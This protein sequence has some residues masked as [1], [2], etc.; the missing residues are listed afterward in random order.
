MQASKR[1]ASGLPGA[2][3]SRPAIDGARVGVVSN[4]DGSYELKLRIPI[5]IGSPRGCPPSS[6]GA[7]RRFLLA[8]RFLRDWAEALNRQVPRLIDVLRYASAINFPWFLNAIRECH[9]GRRIPELTSRDWLEL[10]D[11]VVA[12]RKKRRFSN[13][14]AEVKATETIFASQFY[15]LKRVGRL[16]RKADLPI[17]SESVECTIS[18]ETLPC[19]VCGELVLRYAGILHGFVIRTAPDGARRVHQIPIGIA[20]EAHQIEVD[21]RHRMTT[22]ECLAT[23]SDVL[24]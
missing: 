5:G 14:E 19:D 9:P 11:D 13:A 24:R 21:R 3:N 17:R 7:A 18:D 8:E 10:V 1:S 22:T 20:C 16:L 2:I 23:L 15:S 12:L 4:D 6:L